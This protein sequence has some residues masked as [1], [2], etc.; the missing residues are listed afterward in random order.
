MIDALL[1]GHQAIART[2]FRLLYRYERSPLNPFRRS[3]IMTYLKVLNRMQWFS[4][5][6]ILHF[7]SEKLK[8]LLVHAYENVPYYRRAFDAAGFHPG[9]Y[10]NLDDMRYIPVLTKQAI[11][12]NMN[13]L[14]ASNIPRHEMYENHT[15]GSTG[16]PLTFYQSYDY[17]A[18]SVADIWRNYMMCGFLGGQRRV[19]FWG[20]DY[21][22]SLHVSWPARIF[23]DLL[24]ENMIWYNTFRQ[25]DA[26]M[27]KACRQMRIFKPRLIVGYASSLV[28]FATYMNE[29]GID[30]IRPHAVQSSAEV[31]M[32][33]QRSLVENAFHCRVFDRYGCREVGNIAHECDRH[34]GL[35]LLAENNMT[36]FLTQDGIPADDGDLGFITVTNLNNYAMPFIRYQTGDM[37][38]S[39]IKRCSCGRGL[40]L[41]IE[42]RGRSSDI[43]TTPSGR[44]IH[45]EFFSHLFYKIKGVKQFQII[46]MA[47]NRLTITVVPSA[48]FLADETFRFLEETILTHADPEFLI[49][50]R[51]TESIPVTPSGK[52]RFTISHVPL[53]FQGKAV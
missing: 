51:L 37:G 11:Q 35:H 4:R 22:S 20:S 17:A 47:K 38:I 24:H 30:D 15:G 36:E 34:E 48:G 42:I 39:T 21:D 41:M 53:S 45:G 23:R 27:D 6:E 52:Y 12:E 3:P 7:Q 16:S 49:D 14:I 9:G 44:L 13:A 25:D 29:H 40:P 46:Q 26:L 18:W 28:M 2:A 33:S 50:F 1:A 8:K 19:F 31:L 10:R 32:P 5:D 43:I